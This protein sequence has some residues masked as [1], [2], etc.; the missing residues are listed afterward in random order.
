[1]AVGR[2]TATAVLAVVVLAPSASAA[3]PPPPP[4]SEGRVLDTLFGGRADDVPGTQYREFTTTATAG[5][6]RGHLIRV[7]LANRTVAVRLLRPAVVSAVGT[8]P[9]LAARAGAIG[10]VNGNF[11]DQGGTGASV[12]VELENGALVKS[13][14]PVGR[15]PA[16]PGPPGSSPD[17]V[18][19]IGA[20]GLGRIGRVL[21]SGTVRLSGRDLPLAGLNLYAVPVGGVAAFTPAWGG[22]TRARTVCGSDTDAKAPC[23]RDAVEVRV[24]AGKA[25]AVGP[26]GT[27]AVPA[28]EVALVARD[29]A[30]APLRALRAGDPVDAR[31]TALAPDTPP[32][33]TALGALALVRDGAPWP[34]LQTSERAPRTAVGLSADGRALFLIAVDG[35]QEASVGATLAELGRLVTELGIPQAVALD[36]GG[37]TQMVR[38]PAGGRLGVV[39]VPSSSPLRAVADGLA[40]VPAARDFPSGAGTS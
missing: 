33:R 1:M 34:G 39:N 40:V 37:S 16:P 36:G 17:T 7:D 24:K 26:V 23:A 31:W 22:A 8:V 9:D 6:V 20:D 38:R 15:R 5:R 35:R 2:V 11:F 14:V 30:A 10:G 28:G 29:A 21:F 4:P 19:G 18:V 12:G 13:A 3:P 27:T 25:V 32:L